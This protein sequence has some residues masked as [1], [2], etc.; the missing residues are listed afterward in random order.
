MQ[1]WKYVIDS[2][3]LC[4][5]LINTWLS[6]AGYKHKPT[7]T[8]G[9]GNST[10]FQHHSNVSLST[11]GTITFFFCRFSSSFLK[12]CWNTYSTCLGSCWYDFAPLFTYNEN[13][14]FKHILFLKWVTTSLNLLCI[15][16][17]ILAL[18]AIYASLS[19]P[20]IKINLL[21]SF[22]YTGWIK[23]CIFVLVTYLVLNVCWFSLSSSPHLLWYKWYN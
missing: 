11:S 5:G 14:S 8:F 21:I 9:L 6:L 7:V 16:F 12:G 23:F 18:V 17:I 20:A 22:I 19:G 15:L 2:W 1:M 10:K 13:L 3:T 4:A